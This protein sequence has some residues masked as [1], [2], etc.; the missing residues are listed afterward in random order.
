MLATPARPSRSRFA[1]WEDKHKSTRPFCARPAYNPLSA[2]SLPLPVLIVL[3]SR[4]SEDPEE[5]TDGTRP[6]TPPIRLT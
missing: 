6:L 4:S 1:H 5:N 2:A 3:T